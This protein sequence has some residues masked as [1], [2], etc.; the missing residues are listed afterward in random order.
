MG[1]LVRNPN[2]RMSSMLTAS[3]NARDLAVNR[4]NT[5]RN[6]HFGIGPRPGST[7]RSRIVNGLSRLNRGG[8]GGG[9]GAALEGLTPI[10]RSEAMLNEWERASAAERAYQTQVRRAAANEYWAQRR[11][12]A[13]RGYSE[14]LENC[15]S[16]QC[17]RDRARQQ[18]GTR[19]PR[20]GTWSGEPGNS[21]WTPD[22]GTPAYQALQDTNATRAANGQS[23]LSGVRY[24]NGHPN[25]AP[26][27]N[28]RVRIPNMQ[29]NHSSSP[30]G[31]YHQARE[32]ARVRNG[33]T[34]SRSMETGRTWHHGPDGQRMYLVDQRIH[35]TV[36]TPPGSGTRIAT[37]GVPH[38]GGASMVRSPLY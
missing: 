10:L 35:N 9:F 30:G 11:E 27:S 7:S 18:W 13:Q 5:V 3:R 33:G 32:A 8:S 37:G 34:W 28:S 36:Y 6:A 15:D 31:D 26:F 17:R 21:K 2:A 19:T 12:Q 23:P 4:F 14:A 24:R 29:G 20:G 16:Q 1:N 22:R 25:F 38:S